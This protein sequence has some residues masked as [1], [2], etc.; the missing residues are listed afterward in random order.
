MSWGHLSFAVEAQDL[1]AD[2]GG[3][4]GLDLVQMSEEVEPRSASPVVQLALRQ[5]AQQGRLP[6]VHV[7]QH[8]HP[9]VQE[10]SRVRSSMAGERDHVLVFSSHE[11]MTA[12]ALAKRRRAAWGV[13]LT[14]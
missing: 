11:W 3:A 6:R 4:S 2:A 12:D 5:D 7:P 9:Q 14:C 1:E 10:L 8:R 13:C